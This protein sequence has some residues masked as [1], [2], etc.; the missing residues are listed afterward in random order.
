MR[1]NCG[2]TKRM[3]ALMAVILLTKAVTRPLRK[4]S[5]INGRVTVMKTLKESAP[6]S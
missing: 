4:E 2:V 3:M 5:L 6:I 1:R